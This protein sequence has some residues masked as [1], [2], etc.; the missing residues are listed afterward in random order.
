MTYSCAIW[1]RG[2]ETLEEAQETKLE[3][4]CTKLGAAARRA[5]ARRRLRLGRFAV[6]AAREHGV[7]VT[8]ITLS[9]PQAARARERAA[10]AGVAD[11]VEI[12]VADYR[13]L[14]GEPFDAIAIDRH[15]R[16]RRRGQHRRLRAHARARCWSRAAGCS[17]TAS[18]ACATASPRRARSPS[19]SC[20]PT[21]RRCTSRAIARRARE[22]RAS[23]TDHVE[24]FAPD[25]ARTLRAVAAA[26]RRPTSTRR[27]R[28]AGAER[29]RVWQLYLRAARRGFETGFTSVYQVRANR[30]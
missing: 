19:A 4:V 16:A 5:G 9:E 26:A 29:V 1:S 30:V 27:A 14:R 25:Y 21:P 17:T 24:G 18:R 22:R 23:T 12:R 13:E 3:L 28:L 8:G 11:R 7:H 10:D 2:A 15:G 20:S 6:H